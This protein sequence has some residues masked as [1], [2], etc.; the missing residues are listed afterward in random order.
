[1][2]G[3]SELHESALTPGSEDLDSECQLQRGQHSWTASTKQNRHFPSQ[4]EVPSMTL[5]SGC[6]SSSRLCKEKQYLD[7]C[8]ISVCKMTL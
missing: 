7:L 8:I 2:V 4:C 1:M 5:L 6:G 3:C